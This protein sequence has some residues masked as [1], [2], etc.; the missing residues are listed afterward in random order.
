MSLLLNT[1][2]LATYIICVQEL[3]RGQNFCKIRGLVNN[4]HFSLQ[5]FLIVLVSSFQ[6]AMDC[7]HKV[8]SFIFI[9]NKFC[10]QKLY[11]NFLNENFEKD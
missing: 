8:I 2:M 1:C 3:L 6:Y 10:M 4:C 9:V 7:N 5:N 11:G